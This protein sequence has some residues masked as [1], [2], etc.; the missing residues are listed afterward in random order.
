MNASEF[1]RPPCAILLD[2]KEIENP[3][4]RVKTRSVERLDHGVL[5]RSV[6]VGRTVA[7]AQP[8]DRLDD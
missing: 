8:E 1:E 4:S 7:L 3:Y 2:N 5:V 6:D